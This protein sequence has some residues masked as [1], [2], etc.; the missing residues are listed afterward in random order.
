[1]AK[2][3]ILHTIDDVKHCVRHQLHKDAKL[4]SANVHV[5][6]YLRY[7]FEV[8]CED[9]CSYMDTQDYLGIE[10]AAFKAS[11]LLLDKLDQKITPILNEHLDL[12]V[13]YFNPL[14]SFTGGRQLS[15]Y[16]ILKHCLSLM[17]EQNCFETILVYEGA[18]GPLKADLK[19]F[20]IRI[21]PDNK[22]YIINYKKSS[23]MPT[24]VVISNNDIRALGRQLQK[25]ADNVLNNPTLIQRGTTT[26]NVLVF[27]PADKLIKFLKDKNVYYL[28]LNKTKDALCEYWINQ[29]I[30]SI[31][32]NWPNA[33]FF[34][35]DQGDLLLF[36]YE[37][38]RIDFSKNIAQ[39]LP[40]L[41]QCKNFHIQ[42][43]I[44]NVYWSTPFVNGVGALLFEFFITNGFT[45]VIGV[46]AQSTFFAGQLL[47]AYFAVTV[48]NRCHCY[49]TQ[50]ATQADMKILGLDEVGN[51]T[52]VS[53]NVEVTKQFESM[54]LYDNRVVV[55]IALFLRTTKSFLQVGYISA[56]VKV[57]ERL[58]EYLKDKMDIQI[59]IVTDE[60]PSFENFAMLTMLKKQKNI[61]LIK[62]GGVNNYLK[63]YAPKLFFMDS[64]LA[65]TNDMLWKDTVLILLKDPLNVFYGRALEAL[66]KS[67]YFAGNYH[68]L[69]CLLQLYFEGKLD[70]KQDSTY[71]LQFA[72]H[73]N[74]E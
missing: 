42:N 5:V 11:G 3:V 44:N 2:A 36:L 43:F 54:S 63:K 73:Q 41:Y 66:H 33:T 6:Y 31:D 23:E 59:H 16:M 17:L 26:K 18:L 61:T 58:L 29:D 34:Q 21:F 4:F 19:A 37:T 30:F 62:E 1:M 15:L 47:G 10:M 27:E 53:P 51:N 14:Y 13:R 67:I 70:K 24:G 56:C 46:Q 49:V 35:Q 71:L 20:L 72:K 68:E 32:D 55:D 57:Q 25:N 64:H 50:G 74:V 38:L 60:Q 40:L 8:K 69:E 65:L 7:H 52:V 9:L 45:R 28:E 48:F 39:Y 22:F 12:A